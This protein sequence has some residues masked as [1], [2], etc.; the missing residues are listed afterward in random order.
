MNCPTEKG[1]GG[2]GV[3][4][5]G[6]DVYK[7][8]RCMHW[9]GFLGVPRFGVSSWDVHNLPQTSGACNLYRAITRIF[10]TF[11]LS[12]RAPG[13]RQC[14]ELGRRLGGFRE[15][16]MYHIAIYL[17]PKVPVLEVL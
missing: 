14:R 6:D 13:A 16:S 5:A 9:L 4:D 3:S 7:A 17:G 15:G 12:M 1:G 2:L 8:L 11:V 10:E